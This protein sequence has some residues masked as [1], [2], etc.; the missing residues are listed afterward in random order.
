MRCPSC[1]FPNPQGMRFCGQCGSPLLGAASPAPEALPPA[2]AAE[3]RHI[4][5]LFCDLADSTA[6]SE[7]LDPEELR[8]VVQ[9]YQEAC[10]APVHRFGGHV[11]QYL[12]DGILV[13]FGFPRAQEDAAQRAVRAGLGIVDAIAMLNQRLEAQL[14]IPLTVRVGIHSGPVVIGELGRGATRD[15]LALGRAPNLAARLEALGVP[16]SVLISAATHRLVEGFFRCEPLGVYELKG[17]SQPI[18]VY[19][20]LE[21]SGARSRFEATAQGGLIPMVGREDELASLVGIWRTAAGGALQAILIEGEAGIGKSRLVQSL[22]ERL[23][24]E[25]HVRLELYCSPH[26]QNTALYPF[27]EHLERTAKPDPRVPPQEAVRRLEGLLHQAG[28]HDA[29]SLALTASL[30]SLPSA[31]AAAPPPLPPEQQRQ[32]TLEILVQWVLAQAAEQPALVVV[33]DLHWVDPST[34]EL[35]RLLFERGADAPVLVVATSRPGAEAPWPA[36]SPQAHS[37]RLHSLQP[38][39]IGAM[40]RLLS[41]GRAP[42][43]ELLAELVARSDGVPLFVEELIRL[44]AEA[45]GPGATLAEALP[46]GSV[47]GRLQDLLAERLDRLGPAKRTAQVAA[48]CGREFPVEL[49]LAVSDQEEPAVRRD[50]Q[51]L[52][53][54]G[55]LV[56]HRPPPA[57]SYR[58]R[59][60]LIQEVANESLLRNQRRSYHQRA[61]Q[62]L[63]ERF[64]ETVANRPE[65]LAYHATEGGLTEK[66]IDCW[67]LAGQRAL[68]RSAN[69]EASRHLQRGLE[70][71]HTLA[72][73]SDRDRQELELMTRLGPALMATRGFAAPEVEDLY[74]RARELCRTVGDAQRTFPVLWGLMRVHSARAHLRLAHG[75]GEQLLAMARQTG[76][77]GNLLEAHRMMGSTLYHMGELEQARLHLEEGLALYDPKRQGAGESLY[78][79]PQVHFLFWI[80]YVQWN[81]GRP[82]TALRRSREALALA[83]RLGAPFGV[84]VACVANALVHQF[85]R[86]APQALEKAEAAIALASEHRFPVWREMG[87]IVRGWAWTETGRSEEGLAE[88]RRSLE[89]WRD[90]GISLGTQMFLVIMAES[91]SRLGRAEESL[92][93]LHK[94]KARVDENDERAFEAEVYRLEGEL[95]LER[96][97]ELAERAFRRALA[98][99]HGQRARSLELRAALSLCRLYQG[100][101]RS[102]EAERI[103]SGVYGELEEGFGTSDLRTARALLKDL[104]SR[105]R[106]GSPHLRRS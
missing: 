96:S 43:P 52:R 68:D 84:A 6:L 42:E 5:I 49:L 79:H 26:Y 69:L 77:L 56:R 65:L 20:A 73:S 40:V 38:E 31:E 54:G 74:E 29:Q 7:R 11:A 87:G 91:C 98:V 3:R 94:A 51:R 81:L 62:A 70:L 2:D 1:E 104:A 99:A 35:L 100:Q 22:K 44:V 17:I 88:M 34:V 36:A 66:A 25:P 24:G 93:L 28:L 85:R 80:G 90:L 9:A 12:G 97:Q 27:I 37:I 45:G 53:K 78:L 92:D 83:R 71:L 89:A 4:S 61:A 14:G 21:K 67:Q 75:L 102:V 72:P 19:R 16:N 60:I 33:E 57:E 23:D 8:S 105:R 50:L 106:S 59:H 64:P 15:R 39:Q 10:E 55:V 76:D 103:L 30:L 48:V 13:Y 86:E 18:A 82:D 63:E 95:V 47:P 101:G 58:F 41:P 46:P 32:R